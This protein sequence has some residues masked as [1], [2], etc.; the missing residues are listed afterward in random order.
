MPTINSF[1]WKKSIRITPTMIRCLS[2]PLQGIT[3]NCNRNDTH[4]SKLLSSSGYKLWLRRITGSEIEYSLVEKW[5]ISWTLWLCHSYFDF[6]W[7]YL[8]IWENPSSPYCWRKWVGHPRDPWDPSSVNTSLSGFS[9]DRGRQLMMTE[10]GR[11]QSSRNYWC[12]ST[13]TKSCLMSQR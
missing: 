7:T 8:W 1:R 12:S 3:V 5:L 2:A 9:R 4:L 10:F 6:R 13:V 11:F